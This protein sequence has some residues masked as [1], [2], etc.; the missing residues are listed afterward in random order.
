MTDIQSRIAA[1]RKEIVKTC[2][3]ANRDPNSVNLLAI[4]KTM[5]AEAVGSAIHAG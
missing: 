3:I 1:I 2:Q 4:S 5:D